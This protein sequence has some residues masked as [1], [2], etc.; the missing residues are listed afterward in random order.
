MTVLRAVA[1]RYGLI[2][3]LHEKPFAGINGSGKHL[4]Y[5]IGNADLGS[6]FD[7]G[8]T[9][10]MPTAGPRRFT[11]CRYRSQPGCRPPFPDT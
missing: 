2:C 8:D 3:L 4:N 1:K 5:S 9:P 6:L 10:H 7:P 11:A